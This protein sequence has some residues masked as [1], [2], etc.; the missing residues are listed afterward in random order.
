MAKVKGKTSSPTSK[1]SMPTSG[2]TYSSE[3]SALQGPQPGVGGST[4]R[5][6][7]PN[8]ISRATPFSAPKVTSRNATTPKAQKSGTTSKRKK[9]S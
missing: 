7:K 3:G 8:K 1:G 9:G 5:G 2:Y 6:G 4:G